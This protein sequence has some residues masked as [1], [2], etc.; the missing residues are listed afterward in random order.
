MEL[1]DPCP[2]SRV[3]RTQAGHRAMSQK[4]QKSDNPPGGAPLARRQFGRHD[5]PSA[6]YHFRL[7][8]VGLS[9]AVGGELT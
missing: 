4:C 1:R 7:K 6:C 9:L 5:G 2:L 8:L 3:L